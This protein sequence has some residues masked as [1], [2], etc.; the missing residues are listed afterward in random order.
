MAIFNLAFESISYGA[1]VPLS[2]HELAG[3]LTKTAMQKL[4]DMTPIDVLCFGNQRYCE[5]KDRGV[6]IMSVLGSTEWRRKFD[7]ASN[8]ILLMGRYPL[9]FVHEVRHKYGDDFFLSAVHTRRSKDMYRFAKRS[10][11]VT[12]TRIRGNMLPFDDDVRFQQGTF[13]VQ[14][15]LRDNPAVERWNIES[16]GQVN[17]SEVSILA[18]WPPST[19]HRQKCNA[20]VTALVPGDRLSGDVDL[21]EWLGSWA[22]KSEKHAICLSVDEELTCLGVLLER[23]YLYKGQKHFMKV[24]V[25]YTS[26]PSSAF[27]PTKRVSWKII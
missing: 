5:T 6:A 21:N 14:L 24:G 11:R 16:S 26:V 25:F 7:S 8:E 1:E 15:Q 19:R 12:D 23:V 22:N 4:L 10:G 17:V 13:M 9:N 2:M 20:T 27:P 18:S 3:I